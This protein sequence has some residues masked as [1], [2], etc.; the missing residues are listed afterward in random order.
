[1]CG[2]RG[3]PGAGGDREPPGTHGTRGWPG[4]GP[5]SGL[6]SPGPC[7][8]S[9]LCVV[10][11][12]VCLFDLRSPRVYPRSDGVGGYLSA[13]LQGRALRWRAMP[14]AVPPRHQP[15]LACIVDVTRS[16]TATCACTT[17]KNDSLTPDSVQKNSEPD[18]SNGNHTYPK[19]DS[20]EYSLAFSHNSYSYP[21]TL[22]VQ[23][24]SRYHSQTTAHNHAR[25]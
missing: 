14:L 3:S 24:V 13:N 10:F 18:G 8:A 4:V 23:Y 21:L 25:G 17:Y 16:V 19:T 22:L 6:T 7:P 2:S 9:T 12:I 15:P 20:L 5:G 11:V 1:M